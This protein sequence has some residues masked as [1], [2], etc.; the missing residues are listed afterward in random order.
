MNIIIFFLLTCISL[1]IV[2]LNLVGMKTE[3]PSPQEYF[4][5]ECCPDTAFGCLSRALEQIHQAEVN[6]AHAQ[7]NNKQQPDAEYKCSE[8]AM[9]FSNN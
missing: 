5:C 8:C 4:S 2:P 6:K 1:Q 9:T 3:A 7:P